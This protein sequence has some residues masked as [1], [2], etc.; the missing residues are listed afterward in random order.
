MARMGVEVSASFHLHLRS[1]VCARQCLCQHTRQSPSTSWRSHFTEQRQDHTQTILDKL[2][3]ET[4]R[5]WQG[6]CVR[7]DDQGHT[8]WETYF[9]RAPQKRANTWGRQMER[10]NLEVGMN[11]KFVGRQE[12]RAVRAQ[13]QGR[14]KVLWAEAWAGTGLANR[15]SAGCW[16]G[17]EKHMVA[18]ETEGNHYLTSPHPT[19]LLSPPPLLGAWLS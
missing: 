5:Q 3:E 2:Y 17:Q 19:P 11:P 6:N 8:L 15:G 14:R 1:T 4:R 13:Q 12:A 10:K 16:F 18:E 9:C 7:W